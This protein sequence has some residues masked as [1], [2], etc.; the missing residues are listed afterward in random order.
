[1]ANKGFKFL[2]QVCINSKDPKHRDVYMV[3]ASCIIYISWYFFHIFMTW[4]YCSTMYSIALRHNCISILTEIVFN[5]YIC[6]IIISNL[7]IISQLFCIPFIYPPIS[8]D[9]SEARC[10]YKKY[11]NLYNRLI[12]LTKSEYHGDLFEL[13][14]G[15][16]CSTW[17]TLIEIIGKTSDKTSCTSM[18]P[19]L[20]V[21]NSANS[22]PRWDKN[23]LRKFPPQISLCRIKITVTAV[24]VI[25]TWRLPV[26]F[27]W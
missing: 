25:K 10:K 2:F 1:M 22:S 17:R 3:W 9:A 6:I 15:N 21:T 12:R 16:M 18:I 20:S 14:K 11:R 13:N 23:V 19:I 26:Q 5:N 24:T 4:A 27:E 7:V 8:P